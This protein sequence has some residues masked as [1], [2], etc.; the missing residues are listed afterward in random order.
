MTARKDF[1]DHSVVEPYTLSILLKSSRLDHGAWVQTQRKTCGRV[2]ALTGVRVPDHGM[3]NG[4][5][6][7]SKSLATTS[8]QYNTWIQYSCQRVII[9][10]TPDLYVC[11][12]NLIPLTFPLDGIHVTTCLY[13]FDQ[14]FR[15]TIQATHGLV[16]HVVEGLLVVTYGA[17]VVHTA[18]LGG[19]HV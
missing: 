16:E 6:V 10:V 15:F 1:V 4:L 12:A 13:T 11:F 19:T 18:K 9:Q 7:K 8:I 2:L 14:S 5:I 3:V 17:T